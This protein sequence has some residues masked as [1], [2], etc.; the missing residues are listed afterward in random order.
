M[1]GFWFIENLS[2]RTEHKAFNNYKESSINNEMEWFV[3]DK[4]N[5]KNLSELVSLKPFTSLS[6]VN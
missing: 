1:C 2:S 4:L 6:K 3:V 5:Y